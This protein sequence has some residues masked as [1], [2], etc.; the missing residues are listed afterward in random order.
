MND[1]VFLALSEM[2]EEDNKIRPGKLITIDMEK[3][4]I[5]KLMLLAEIEDISF[6]DYI[7]NLLRKKI[8]NLNLEKN[9]S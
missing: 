8:E 2:H 3:S 9:N 6:N 5:Y 1:Q 7:N 4:Q